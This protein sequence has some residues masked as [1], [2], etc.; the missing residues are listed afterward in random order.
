MQRRPQTSR[1]TH[2]A[3]F[4]MLDPFGHM[5]TVHYLTFFLEHRFEAL[6]ADVGLDLAAI[7]KLPFIFV[8]Q[9]ADLTFFKAVAGDEVFTISSHVRE[10]GDVDCRVRCELQKADG[11]LAATCELTHDL[12][13]RIMDDEERHTKFSYGF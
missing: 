4:L 2:R 13:A 10:F 8:T 9:R 1:T 5:N 12:D 11:S 6:R 7:G 3:S